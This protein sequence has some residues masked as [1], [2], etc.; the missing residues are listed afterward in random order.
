M[1]IFVSGSCGGAFTSI[2]T[3]PISTI[4][5]QHQVV[6]NLGM[7]ETIKHM[8][9]MGGLRVFYRAYMCGFTLEFFER[10][11]YLTTYETTKTN[12]NYWKTYLKE[13]QNQSQSHSHNQIRNIREQQVTLSDRMIA[14]VFA[15]FV[16]WMIIYPMDVIRSRMQVDLQ[17]K[18]FPTFYTCLKL[19]IAEGGWK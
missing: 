4:K 10:G 13:N 5:I 3:T 2:F 6:S 7:I 16:S 17:R 12:L 19:T 14:A 15:S 9:S 11:I 8:Y 18:K 1:I